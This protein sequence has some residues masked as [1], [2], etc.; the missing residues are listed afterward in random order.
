MTLNTLFP[1]VLMISSAIYAFKTRHLPETYSEVKSIGISMYLTLFIVTI[2]LALTML[3][4]MKGFTGTYILC[5]TFQASAIVALI[6]QY[7][8]KIII[9]YWK[10]NEDLSVVNTYNTTFIVDT[11]DPVIFRNNHAESTHD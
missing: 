6:G 5:F 3:L 7:A 8:M 9:L 4:D 11:L 10:K 2:C 1:A